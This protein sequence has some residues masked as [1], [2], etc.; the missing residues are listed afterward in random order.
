MIIRCPNCNTGY[1][2]PVEKLGKGRTVK[3][4]QCAHSWFQEKVVIPTPEEVAPVAVANETAA[5][6][7][8]LP[9]MNDQLDASLPSSKKPVNKSR[10]ALILAAVIATVGIVI[11]TVVLLADSFKG[12]NPVVDD[13]Y[14]AMGLKES[15]PNIE[16]HGLI[17]PEE[18]VERTLSEAEPTTLTF[19]GTVKNP[20][21]TESAIPR[22]VVSL[23]N[24]Q[25]VLLD[26]WPAYVAKR[27]LKAG[28][29]AKWTCRFFNPPL[30]KISEHRV[31][32]EA[33]S[34]TPLKK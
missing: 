29:E 18:N 26:K 5:E 33:R 21:E 22:I 32:F 23:Y 27:T 14:G 11:I 8:P 28:E 13:V 16:N 3:C 17:L 19:T 6:T 25:G 30:E 24:E 10:I 12:D 7:P 1:N 15:D 4:T 9:P 2:L 31:T 20:N 34:A